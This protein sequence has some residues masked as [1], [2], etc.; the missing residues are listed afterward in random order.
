[1]INHHNESHAEDRSNSLQFVQMCSRKKELKKSSTKGREAA[2]KEMT[3]LH[4]HV[5]FEPIDV[6]A[7]SKTEH[8]RSIESLMLLVEK[9]DGTTKG[10]TIANSSTQSSYMPK[11][12]ASS[13]VVA[14]ESLLTSRV[15]DTK[16]KQDDAFV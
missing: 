3:Q 15:I 8:K 13:P 1:M 5:T 11:E 12:E 16:E 2:L 4:R 14:V 6:N 7:L 10:R 9:R